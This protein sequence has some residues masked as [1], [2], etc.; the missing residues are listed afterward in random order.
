[1]ETRICNKC[2]VEKPIT[3]FGINRANNSKAYRKQDKYKN[4]C[5]DCVAEYARQWRAKNKGY[6]G[7]GKLKKFDEVDP[8]L[9]ST[10][11]AKIADVK[12]NNQRRSKKPFDIDIDLIYD[13]YQRQNGKCRYT[14]EDFTLEKGHPGN[15][16]IDKIDPELGYVKDNVQLVCWAVNR[17]KGDLTEAQFINMCKAVVEGATTIP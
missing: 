13:L 9:I 12:G 5:K 3:E 11:R 6:T 7:S 10:L 17:A 4:S 16:S 2:D 1:M 8:K 15:I 14:G